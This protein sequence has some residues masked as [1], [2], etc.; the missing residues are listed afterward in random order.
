MIGSNP[1]AWNKLAKPHCHFN[2]LQALFIFFQKEKIFM[3]V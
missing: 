1:D 2:Y 3:H